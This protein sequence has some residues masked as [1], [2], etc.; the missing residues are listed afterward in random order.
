MKVS[1]INRRVF[2]RSACATLA[3]PWLESFAPVRAAAPVRM[4]FLFQPN[5]VLPSAWTPVNE[6]PN[7]TL[8]PTLEPLAD[9]R[10]RTLVLT[11]LR[12]ANS[13]T[14]EG[15]YVKT[16]ALLSGA[17]VHKTGGRDLRVGTTIDQHAAH[18]RGHETR[19]PSLV[20]GLEGVRHAVDMGY[21][22]VYGAHLSWRTPTQPASK[23]TSP[24]RAFDRLFRATR[25][26]PQGGSIL[27]LVTEE[28]ASLRRRAGTSDRGKLDEYLESVRALERRL[29]HVDPVAPTS[30]LDE[31]PQDFQDRAEAMLDIMALALAT[32]ATRIASLMFGNAVSGRNFSFLDGVDGGFHPISHHEDKPEQQRKYQLINRWHVERLAGLL[33]RL[34]ERQ[35]AGGSLLDRTLVFYGSG[36]RDGNRHDPNNLPIL[37]A[38]GQAAGIARG[39]HLRFPQHTKLCHLYVSMLNAFGVPTERFGDAEGPLAGVL[40]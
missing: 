19:I 2:L 29:E 26:L 31:D 13:M 4:L 17:P 14:G 33:R 6:G 32:D 23:E 21:S 27:D 30:T 39:A 37:L 18:A 40:A 22:T 35:E 5:G 11:G 3:L 36:L 24:R 12:N 15:H 10:E 25:R 28:A 7:W 20:L 38:G 8:S 1:N 16:T 34:D 9:F